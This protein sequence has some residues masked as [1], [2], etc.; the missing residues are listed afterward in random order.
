MLSVIMPAYHERKTLPQALGTLVPRAREVGAEV[1]V[2]DGGS[3]DGTQA[4][5]RRFPEVTL[6]TSP[7]GRGIQMNCGA[8]RAA[9]SLLV[10]VPADTRLPADALSCLARIDREGRHA[11]GGFHQE[12]D[13]RRPLLRAISALHNLRAALTGVFYGD[14]VPFVRRD[15]FLELGGYRE[16]VD[17]EDVEFGSRLRRRVRPRMLKLRVTTSSRRFDR[18]GDLRATVEA[19]GLL[20]CW[21]SLCRA[22]RSRT[23]FTPVR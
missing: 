6:L 8:R 11:A 21:V 19:A 20:F 12:F 9:G 2:V 10:F 4:E 23:F 22:R 5:A 15:L 17:M 16:G 1:I 7:R 13:Q 14:Q 18:F 3:A